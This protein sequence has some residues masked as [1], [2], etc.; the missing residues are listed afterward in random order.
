MRKLS[1]RLTLLLGFLLVSLLLGA[2]AARALLVLEQFADQ[3]RA[4]AAQAVQMTSDIQLLAE[5][6]V[7]LERSARQ[8][9]VLRDTA[10]LE[11]F[12]GIHAGARQV[13]E[14]IQSV[15][16]APIEDAA[17]GWRQAADDA[18]QGLAQLDG[19]AALGALARLGVHNA[20]LADAGRQWIDAQGANLLQALERNRHLLTLQV[21]VAISAALLIALAIA[22][23][24]VRPVSALEA[25]IGRLGVG[26]FEQAVV[27][28]GPEDLQRLGER[29]DWLRQ[30]LA[31]LEADRVRVLRHVSHELKTPLAALREGIALLQ[32]EV[33]GPLTANQ[34]EVARILEQNARGLQ[35]QIEDLLN[36]HA[37]VFDAGHLRPTRVAL[38]DLLMAVVEE[39]RLQA[40]SRR[41]HVTIEADRAQATLDADK[42]HVALGNLL[43]NAIIFSPEGGE[44]RLAAHAADGRVTIDCIDAGPGVAVADTERIFEP[45]VQGRQRPEW[46]PPGS[47]VGLSIVRELVAAQRGRVFLVPSSGGA[48]FR[49]E[50]PDED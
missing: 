45:F 37:T 4:G 9:L 31:E 38:R 34:Q 27:I 13:V 44:I 10:L 28:R 43:S 50:L 15:H 17:N 25:A 6:S 46:A 3:S 24:L 5:R 42:L 39:Q 47:G 36:Y 40:Q 12:A 14:R 19:D 33:V 22:W 16:V 8:Y 35:R 41:L 7:D 48:H 11:R 23:W 32:D 30:R 2:A 21:V 29:L 20:G 1:F 18:A 26:H 49:M